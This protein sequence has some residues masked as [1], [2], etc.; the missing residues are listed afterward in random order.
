MTTDTTE[1][2]VCQS[3]MLLDPRALLLVYR[4]GTPCG[5]GVGMAACTSLGVLVTSHSGLCEL[6][7]FELRTRGKWFGNSPDYVIGISAL[8]QPIHFGFYDCAGW[9]GNLAFTGPASAR[10]LLVTDSGNDAVHVMDVV[11]RSHV[12]YLA[13][14]GTIRGPRGVAAWGSLAA[15]SVFTHSLTE[16]HVVEL[17][18]GGGVEWTRVRVVGGT[19]GTPEFSHWRLRNPMGLRFTHDGTRLVVA[20]FARDCVSMFRVEDGTFAG[21][22]A[23][24]AIH[25][26]DAE[27]VEGGWLMACS[28]PHILQCRLSDEPGFGIDKYISVS[29]PVHSSPRLKHASALV[30]VP[31]FGLVVREMQ[32]G[33]LWMYSTPDLVKMR[34]MSCMRVAW[35]VGVSRGIQHRKQQGELRGK[36]RKSGM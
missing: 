11:G 18:E 24:G 3:Q 2:D 28:G 35:M 23:A 16:G 4:E 21:H 19:D 17:F 7:V 9:S 10:R 36:T 5:L 6:W 20:N 8:P 30:T 22:I 25:V 26:R 14:P 27:K 29:S 1:A 34:T 12:G 31:G 15:V 33:R 13:A 32:D